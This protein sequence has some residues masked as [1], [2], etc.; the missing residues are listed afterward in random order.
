MKTER[1]VIIKLAVLLF[2][3]AVLAVV[4]VSKM[5]GEWKEEAFSEKY[6][7][8]K[9][10][11][12]ELGFTVYTAKEWDAWFRAYHREYLTGEMLVQ[13]LDRLGV[14]EAAEYSGGAKRRAVTR[15]EWNLVYA[16]IRDLLDMRAVIGERTLLILDVMELEKE[17][18]L[19]TNQGDFYTALP[20][21]Y[22]T[23]WTGYEVYTQ[24]DRCVGIRQISQAEQVIENTYLKSFT[25]GGIQFL[26]D[27]AV[28]EKETA[29][30]AADVKSG[31]GDL[32]FAEG[33]L[34][35]IRRK[36][37]VIQGDMLSCDD[38]E[39]EIEG[40]GK[41]A[42]P[43]KLP[44]YQTYGDAAERSISDVVLGNMCVE[45]VTAGE[46]VCAILIR[47]PAKIEQIR[48]LLLA[49]D[50]TNFRNN[51]FLK[52]TV[53]M[54]VHCGKT[55]QRI[56]PGTVVNTADYL[57]AE[58]GAVC[59]AAP[60]SQDGSIY[61]CSSDGTV[62]SN[63]YAG[64]MEIRAYGKKG[65]TVVNELP[66][67]QYLYA[68]VPSEMPS[69]YAPEALKAQAVCARS[70]AYGQLLRA[71]LMA[72][73][74]HINDST[75]YQVYNKV[76]QTPQSV[77]AVDATNGQVLMYQGNVVEAYYFSTSM[78]YTDT[79]EVWNVEDLSS[80]GYLKAACLLNEAYDGDLSQEKAFL[81]YIQAKPDGYE[82][83]MRYYRWF[84]TAALSGK[85]QQ[86]NQILTERKKVSPRNVRFYEP[87]GV[88]ETKNL[89]QMGGLT[90]LSVEKRSKSGSILT[91][92]IQ[93]EHGLVRVWTE[94]NIRKILGCLAE[95]IVYADSSESAA[96]AML[97]SA[98]CAI[99]A[100]E[101]G[102]LLFSGG[103]YGH[104][105]GMSQN[106]ANK[107][108]EQGMNFT[109]ILDFFY[110]D[111]TIENMKGI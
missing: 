14:S 50:G 39:I 64:T 9:E 61:L 86:I 13:L 65:Y 91:L 107:L 102:T 56:E 8:V 67:E 7:S 12:E 25:D 76:E 51:V 26:Y 33:E 1:N 4:F 30:L 23:A 6:I 108:A 103:G 36:T 44:V 111:I 74:A 66:F 73:G 87:D 60:E 94:Y 28:Y 80:C 81:A 71:D 46:E 15:E 70:Y 47:E 2:L 85:T 59:V 96:P 3:L 98:F 31:V 109:E 41:I 69:Q 24:K 83:D 52:S 79:A 42:H 21:T 110:Q 93:Y 49:E 45:Y 78:G 38:T 84:A 40:Y 37:D 77:A 92:C 16:Q 57:A 17:T 62:V 27:G 106:G 35:T 53:S 90:G 104:G 89:G 11:K 29:S 20:R 95:K 75:A 63:G 32:V 97:P 68:V 88:T 54:V 100:Q 43:G 48:V 10:V 22:F 105:L 58:H 18:L 99:T 55:K 34:R 19:V 72:Y 101:D 5:D 82:S